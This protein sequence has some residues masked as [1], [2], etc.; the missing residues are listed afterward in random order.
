MT[1]DDSIQREFTGGMLR[2]VNYFFKSRVGAAA[3]GGDDVPPEVGPCLSTTAVDAS[4][5][6]SELE[7]PGGIL[8]RV[9]VKLIERFQCLIELH[10]LGELDISRRRRWSL[11]VCSVFDLRCH[12]DFQGRGL[13]DK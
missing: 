5:G 13:V 10:Q 7:Q 2:R 3:V 8:L 11:G 1:N 6:T 4:D 9:V 12:G